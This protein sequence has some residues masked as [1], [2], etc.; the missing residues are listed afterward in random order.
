MSKF[1]MIWARHCQASQPEQGQALFFSG[2]ELCL[3][4]MFFCLISLGHITHLTPKAPKIIIVKLT[5]SVDPDEAA[6]NELPHLDLHS[7]PS[8]L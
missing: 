2:S 7:L 4:C 1:Y 8:S 6:Q 5:N 3:F